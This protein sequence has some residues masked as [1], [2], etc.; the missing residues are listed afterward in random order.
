MR[1]HFIYSL[2]LLPCSIL[3]PVNAQKNEESCAFSCPAADTL[4]QPL[5][6]R[7][8]AIGQ[9]SFYSIFECMWGTVLFSTYSANPEILYIRYTESRS[10]SGTHKCSYDKASRCGLIGIHVFF[11]SRTHT[12]IL[13]RKPELNAL[14]SLE[15]GVQRLLL[16]AP[17]ES[18]NSPIERERYRHGWKRG[19]IYYTWRSIRH[20]IETPDQLKYECQNTRSSS[21]VFHGCLWDVPRPR[22]AVAD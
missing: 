14:D 20:K 13:W 6:K 8:D 18:A 19:D 15:T 9:Q 11:V 3:C 2:F 10:Q 21:G 5:V 12:E 4:S 1:P 7:A 16:R 22:S 17:K